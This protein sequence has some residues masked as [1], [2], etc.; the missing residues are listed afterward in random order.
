VGKGVMIRPKGSR[1]KGKFRDG[2]FYERDRD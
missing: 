1:I 2:K